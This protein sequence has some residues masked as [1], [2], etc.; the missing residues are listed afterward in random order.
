MKP[1][2]HRSG[3]CKSWWGE[4][5]RRVVSATRKPPF[6][7]GNR[8][9]RDACSAQAQIEP[10][11]V[12]GSLKP[13]KTGQ[14]NKKYTRKKRNTPTQQS[15]QT[16]FKPPSPKTEH[17]TPA[18]GKKHTQAA[19][20][21][22]P[23]ASGGLLRLRALPAAKHRGLALHAVQ[24]GGPVQGRGRLIL[25]ETNPDISVFQGP[26]GIGKNMCCKK[27]VC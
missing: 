11:L 22:T 18:E 3:G 26:H 16:P 13:V 21:R 6:P 5:H 12:S 2:S 24:D 27:G 25:S 19:G 10:K 23:P 17:G 20:G 9:L 15:Q 1:K 4:S 8:P 7:C 14:A